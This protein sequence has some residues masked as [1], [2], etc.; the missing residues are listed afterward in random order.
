[1]HFKRNQLEKSINVG[2]DEITELFNLVLHRYQGIMQQ[3]V[4][5]SNIVLVHVERVFYK[6]HKISVNQGEDY[7]DFLQWLENRKVTINP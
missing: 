7:K 2:S 3:S 4:K 1:M 6:C 5:S